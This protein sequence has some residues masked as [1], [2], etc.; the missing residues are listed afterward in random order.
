MTDQ[1]M[2][3]QLKE[4]YNMHQYMLLMHFNSRLFVKD[5]CKYR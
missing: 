3:R 2:L 5:G 4:P 1:N